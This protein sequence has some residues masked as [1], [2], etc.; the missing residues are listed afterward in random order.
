[1]PYILNKTN[2]TVIATVQDASLDQTTDL[3]FVGRNYAGYGEWQ[4]ENFLKLLENF[5]NTLP[6]LKPISGQ[7]WY[8]LSTR[9]IN[10][11]DGANWK[12]FATSV[13]STDDPS[14]N[15]S[16]D[17][18]AGDLW[19]DTRE[20]QLYV[21][22]GTEF[23]L[24]GPA[25][26]A[27]TKAVWR[28]DVE[29]AV[30]DNLAVPK[31]SIKAL[32]GAE[33]NVIAVVSNEAYIVATPDVPP[34]PSFSLPTGH[35]VAKG[36]TLVGADPITGQSDNN[37]IYFWGSAKHASSSTVS[38]GTLG[39]AAQPSPTVQGEYSIPYLGTSVDGV[40]SVYST[41]TFF[42]DPSDNSVTADLFK[43]TATAAYYADLAERYEADAVYEPGTVLI[44]GGNK[45]VTVTSD[46]SDTKVIGVVSTNPAYMMNA[47]AGPDNTHPYIALRGRVPVKVVGTVF[48]GDLL[49][50]SAFP[51]YAQ[52]YDAATCNPNAVFAKALGANIEGYGVVEAVI[53]G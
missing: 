51:G 46:F 12:P 6:P 14:T 42:Y 16:I 29:Y 5:S 52:A 36:I 19:F 22:N 31:Y 28:G 48:R 45:E 30:E 10:V 25:G 27:D 8:D 17:F 7:L 18:Q 26:G 35:K 43:G 15:T 21:Y 53:L 2:G 49:V 40:S 24:V 50:T 23:I 37:G 44:I 38:A 34:F 1:M 11:Y 41:S 4:N 33:N 9:S 32:L 20:E 13:N 39:V 47:S 3:I